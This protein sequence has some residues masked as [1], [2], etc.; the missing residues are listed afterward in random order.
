MGVIF[1][2]KNNTPITIEKDLMVKYRTESER[3]RTE[4]EQS[5][6]GNVMGREGTNRWESDGKLRTYSN[7]LPHLI[8]IYR[9][10]SE[11][12]QRL[13]MCLLVLHTHTRTRA[14]TH[15]YTQSSDICKENLVM[16]LDQKL[17]QRKK[18]KCPTLPHYTSSCCLQLF[19]LN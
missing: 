8:V 17:F 2:D 4:R 3:G 1:D 5:Q 19:L 16:Q 14:C 11:P 9:Y 7:S 10:N 13:T 15:A 18:K 12:C 6:D